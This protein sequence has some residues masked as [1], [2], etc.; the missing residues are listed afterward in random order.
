M[1]TSDRVLKNVSSFDKLEL[2]IVTP[3]NSPSNKVVTSTADAVISNNSSIDDSVRPKKK[4]RMSCIDEILNKG[5]DN[6]TNEEVSRDHK[7]KL[8]NNLIKIESEK[9][10]RI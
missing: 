6:R 2:L 3:N 4:K 5:K 10:N 9:I 7:Q 1:D 8:T